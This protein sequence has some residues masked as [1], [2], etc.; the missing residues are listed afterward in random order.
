MDYAI[1]TRGLSKQFG[2]TLAFVG[3]DLQ[4]EH[5]QIFGLLGPDG[6]GK[7]SLI[8]VILDIYSKTSGVKCVLGQADFDN[9]RDYIG[10]VPQKFSLYSDLTVWENIELFGRLYGAN[11]LQ[12]KELG[13]FVLEF[14]QLIDFKQRLSGNLSGGM[15]QK[16][17]LATGLL[18]KPKILFMDEPTTGV[19]PV[20]RRQ[21]WQMLYRLREQ[22][23]TIFVST[24]YMDEAEL[25]TKVGF[26]L[27][28]RLIAQDHPVNLKNNFPYIILETITDSRVAARVLTGLE[29]V[30]SVNVVGEKL[31]IAVENE[32]EGKRLL[33]Q[34][35]QNSGL[36][37]S[38]I[39]L[40]LVTMEDVFVY[41][42]GQNATL[43][44]NQADIK[45]RHG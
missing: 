24:P 30:R 42:A 2:K 11:P 4:V 22:G 3:V 6:A 35:L 26:M 25:C 17:A 40:E 20:S 27:A 15:K 45:E 9:V 16:L 44:Q 1:E 21:F 37:F 12:I 32:T 23:M 38:E 31:R 7:T 8:R 43:P 33:V 29:W 39:S 19:D 28:G 36:I 10:Y 18:H 5:G 13:D 14:T 41:F 34:K